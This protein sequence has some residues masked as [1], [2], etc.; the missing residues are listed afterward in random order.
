[1]GY[2][3]M[4]SVS[5]RK[6]RTRGP[7]PGAAKEGTTLAVQT[8]GTCKAPGGTTGYTPT[9]L[10]HDPANGGMKSPKIPVAP[11]K[12]KAACWLLPISVVDDVCGCG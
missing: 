4:G 8:G 10:D 11:G 9:R 5:T 6:A 3:R 2:Q 7:K 12:P 1:M